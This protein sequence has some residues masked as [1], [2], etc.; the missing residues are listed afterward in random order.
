MNKILFTA[1][2]IGIVSAFS[3]QAFSWLIPFTKKTFDE[4]TGTRIDALTKTTYV[5]IV[6]L[7]VSF[8]SMMLFDYLIRKK[9]QQWLENFSL[10]FSML[11][12]M[13]AAVVLGLGG[14]I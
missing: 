10:A 9:G 6:V 14:I 7:F 11:L 8:L 2:F 12:G 5:P 13:T 4:A 1:V 3:G